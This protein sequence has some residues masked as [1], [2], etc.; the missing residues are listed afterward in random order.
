MDHI[1]TLREI[2]NWTE[3]DQHVTLPN[4]QRGFV[5]KAAQIENLWDSLLRGYPIGAVVLAP[6]LNEPGKFELLDGQQRATAIAL[7][8]GKKPFKKETQEYYKIFIDLERP[9][10][11]DSR[12]FVFRVITKAH[13]WGY[14]WNDN[15]KTLSMEEKRDAMARFYQ[16]ED[17]LHDLS[18][19]FPYDAVFP[20]P[21]HFFLEAAMNDSDIKELLTTIKTQWL[22]ATGNNM[23]DQVK[24]CWKREVNSLL[25]KQRL[26]KGKVILKQQLLKDDQLDG[27]IKQLYDHFTY[28]LSTQRILAHYLDFDRIKKQELEEDIEGIDVTHVDRNLDT[29]TEEQ[30]LEKDSIENLFIRMNS[31][32]TII[33]GEELNYSIFKSQLKDTK[34]IDKINAACKDYIKP[35]RLIA[36]TYLLYRHEYGHGDSININI[37]PR[38]F[39]K[40]LLEGEIPKKDIKKKPIPFEEYLNNLLS[41]DIGK[42][43]ARTLLEY[44]Y[45]LLEYSKDFPFALPHLIVCKLADKAPEI[46]FML[47]YRIRIIKDINIE[48]DIELHK[49]I[50]GVIS[51]LMWLG[52]GE[53]QRDHSKV[54]ANIWPAVRYLETHHYWSSAI[55]QRASLDQVIYPI[56]SFKKL[57][58]GKKIKKILTTVKRG[59]TNVW[60]KLYKETKFYDFIYTVFTEKDLVL[61]S[62]RAFLYTMFK[63]IEYHTEDTNIP[64]DWDHI[65]ASKYRKNKKRLPKVI[66]D[67]YNTNGNMRAWPYDLNRMDQDDAPGVKLNPFRERNGQDDLSVDLTELEKLWS[68]F[69][70]KQQDSELIRSISELKFKLK[71][72]SFCNHK[73]WLVQLNV[74][75]KFSPMEV[76][77]LIV[78]RNIALVN[79]WYNQL[80]IEKLLLL[81]KKYTIENLLNKNQWHPLTKK[82]KELYEILYFE[83]CI[84]QVTKAFL[85]EGS[86]AYFYIIYNDGD[87]DILKNDDIAFGI[88]SQDEK[89]IRSLKYSDTVVSFT[90][91]EK[92]SLSGFFTLIS[93]HIESYN[94]IKLDFSNWI[95]KIKP[96]K[97]ADLLSEKFLSSINKINLPLNRTR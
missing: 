73:D 61:Y 68:K 74:D 25:E 88:Y 40:A 77:R 8:F 2:A 95:T 81:D 60:D 48:H 51:I 31:G 55:I 65:F 7:G 67:W 4:V 42:N 13:P 71:E 86:T 10:P 14:E 82:D 37:K 56:P 91:Q 45:Y 87:N 24:D 30:K 76:Y 32:G 90:N 18:H 33:K 57:N 34:L 89:F 83:N 41:D 44:A 21:V 6:K 19:Y 50:L 93:H 49:K 5:W 17:H 29:I 46:M 53:K 64:F 63:S 69:I 12:R 80:E 84:T 1:F 39:Q 97:T 20:L 15:A 96:K 92:Q 78:D 66:T 59:S 3:E 54:L 38:Q 72:W 94:K 75:L 62:Q 26:A 28:M 27:R 9:S 79:E 85:I 70:Q 58:E 16:V 36:L 22:D 47:L 52:R 23:W 11:D 43:N 35:S